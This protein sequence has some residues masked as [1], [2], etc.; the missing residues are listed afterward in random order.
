MNLKAIGRFLRKY[1]LSMTLMLDRRMTAFYRTSFLS[2][3]MGQPFF[4][5]LAGSAMSLEE[6]ASG[7]K[8]SDMDALKAWLDFGVSVGALKKAGPSGYILKDSL[9]RRLAAGK[10]EAWRAYFRLRVEVFQ[11]HIVKTPDLLAQGRAIPL[12]DEHGRLYADSSRTAEPVVMDVVDE[13]TPRQGPCRLLEVG[14]GSGVYLRRACEAN[15]ELTAVGVEM[16]A[17][18]ANIARSA[19]QE[20]GLGGR[21]SLLHGDVRDLV[22][23]QPFDMLTMHNLIYYFPKKERVDTLSRLRALL[24]PGGRIVLTTLCNASVPSIKVMNLWTSMTEGSGPLP[25]HEELD[26]MLLRAG[27]VKPRSR[28]IIPAFWCVQAVK[29]D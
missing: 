20:W 16:Q 11:E 10:A 14:C 26:A 2:A 8:I 15:P 7:M 3:L 6:I 21:V 25:E 27:Y 4:E 22:P 23:D 1:P 28:E 19:I 12:R 17:S 24:K 13:T 9:T 18:T 29:A 5:H